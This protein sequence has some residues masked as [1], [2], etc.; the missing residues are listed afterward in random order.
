M[1]WTRGSVT[2]INTDSLIASIVDSKTGEQTE[3]KYDYFL[4]AT[5]LR[6]VWPVVPQSLTKK[7]YQIETGDHVHSVRNAVDGVVVI[8]GGAVG[9]EMAA[10][11]K[12]VQPSLRVTLIHSRDKLLS[13]EPL[14]DEFRDTSLAALKE[15]GVEV[16]LGR[17]RVAGQVPIT[18]AEGRPVEMLTLEDGSHVV[19]SHV[20]NAISKSV[21]STTYLPSSV[22]D[23]EGLVKIN[24]Q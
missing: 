11:L 12:L 13:A 2:K 15:H 3:Q 14:P 7:Q 17:G 9:I 21:P 16:I 22:L 5:G 23:G 18:N 1:R 8:G 20:I 10:E 24:K 4:A 19:A 6:R